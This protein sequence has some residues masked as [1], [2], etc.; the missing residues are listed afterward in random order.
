MFFSI[1]S[2]FHKPVS[3]HS[4][5]QSLYQR[6][7]TVLPLLNRWVCSTGTKS[8]QQKMLRTHC[9]LPY[10]QKKISSLSKLKIQW[11]LFLGISFSPWKWSHNTLK[12]RESSEAF[13]HKEQHTGYCSA[14]GVDW[15]S[16]TNKKFLSF[17]PATE[18]WDWYLFQIFIIYYFLSLHRN[19]HS[20]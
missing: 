16:T 4:H 13:L 20:L 18:S 9:M 15:Y 6:G 11:R 14:L 7:Q 2:Q 12:A 3:A 5:S 10:I 1:S 17:L 8:Q 19:T